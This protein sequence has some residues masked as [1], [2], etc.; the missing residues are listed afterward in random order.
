MHM[1]C[2]R[3]LSTR[4]TRYGGGLV[5]TEGA[6]TRSNFVKRRPMLVAALIVLLVVVVVGVGVVIVANPFATKTP[7]ASQE[8]IWQAITG[9]VRDGQPSK[10]AAL[11]AFAYA[12]GIDI[13]GVQIPAGVDGTDVPDE[14]TMVASWVQQYWSQLTPDQQ[15]VITPFLEPGPNDT[16]IKLDLRSPGGA[17]HSRQIANTQALGVTAARA[18]MPIARRPVG[19]PADAPDDALQI[20]FRRDLLADIAHIGERLGLPPISDEVGFFFWSDVTLDFSEKDGGN[21]AF[22]TNGIETGA[23][24]SPCNITVYRNTWQGQQANGDKLPD[25]LHVQLT[26]EVIHCY[27]N[28]IWGSN[29]IANSIPKW[30]TE[31]TALWLAA[32]DTKLLEPLVAS[33]W[34]AGY[35]ALPERPLTNR[36]YDAYG[37]FALLDHQG[38]DLWSL[39]VPAWKAAA[40]AAATV[41]ENS[42]N[43][44]IAALNGDATDVRNAWAPSYLRQDSWGDPW[45]AYG[46]GLPDDAQIIRHPIGA[47]QDPGFLGEQDSRSNTVDEVQESAGEIVLVNTNGIASAQDNAGHSKLA[48]QSARLCV[49]GDCVCP[50]NSAR[51][52]Q[53]MADQDMTMPF[54]L[55]LN[56]PSG[57]AK[58]Q[59][60]GRKLDDECGTHKNDAPW[61][62]PSSPGSGDPLCGTG[63]AGDNGDPHLRTVDNVYYEFQAAGEFT[64]LRSADASLE[65]Q[66]RQEPYE[67]SDHVSINTAVVARDNGHKVGVYFSAGALVARVD[68]NVVDASVAID[69]GNDARVSHHER[70][71]Q[72]DFPDGTQLWALQVGSYGINAQVRPSDGLRRYGVGILGPVV[73]GGLPVPKLPDG[74]RL[75]RAS[76]AHQ[77]YG[78]IYHDF[79]NAWRV[80]AASSLFDY[81]A[82]RTTASYT[83]AAFPKEESE[84]A[85]ADL[86]DAQRSQ[87]A[88]ACADTTDLGLLEQCLF[89]VS[90]TGDDGFANVYSEIGDLVTLGPGTLDLP[91]GTGPTPTPEPTPGVPGS[92]EPTGTQAPKPAN[93]LLTGLE[94]LKGSA[95]GPDGTLYLSISYPNGT[96][97]LLAVDPAAGQILNQVS[98]LGGGQLA[99]AAGSVWA[100]EFTGGGSDCSITRLD[101]VTLA[102]Q[103]TI[104]TPCDFIGTTFASTGDAVWFLDNTL[105]GYTKEGVRRIDPQTNTATEPVVLPFTNGLLYG[106]NTGL[107]Y[108][109]GVNVGWY[110]LP[111]GQTQLQS[112]G[113]RQSP[114]FPTGVGLW[115]RNE[116]AA[117]FFT[118]DGPATQSIP[119][120]GPLVSADD[121]AVY[122]EQSSRTGDTS[123]LWRYPISGADPVLVASAP[124]P[125]GDEA[126][127]YFDDDPPL[128]SPGGLVKLWLALPTATSESALLAQWI[129]IS[130]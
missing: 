19:A 36:G 21:T 65:I 11:Q 78:L 69:L 43:A 34:R 77:R 99:V 98:A 110:R 18:Q 16:V 39:L 103:A 129:P 93:A 52:G 31:G 49:Q 26:H 105:E 55:A 23:G 14:G 117:E 22:E 96:F 45:I 83:N 13:P 59:V 70:G 64:L 128:V 41:G 108:G 25:V 97:K 104:S 29:A 107:I 46:F 5:M 72:I 113:L 127:S 20:A 75:P 12:Y 94:N 6:S 9:K 116:Q 2:G 67:D 111:V 84:L 121:L 48:F 35:F 81:D 79:A 61:T 100:G 62:P 92:S 88:G 27:Q 60:V 47:S 114:V 125:Y 124:E 15:N 37:Y 87:A 38:R 120:D 63:C 102:V 8:T 56:A 3:D 51:A 17:T 58:Y 106:T 76:D 54:V 90:V 126:F 50:A 53:K 73:P 30:I 42:S 95:V 10:D 74:T 1:V 130:P 57:G 89:D 71:F 86:T 68:G 44:F 115:S 101:A 40:A 85:P 112:L 118:Q 28:T 119:I 33:T 32:D 80:S 122:V 24:Y 7:T 82:G 123:E 4:G 66:A 109:E 91:T